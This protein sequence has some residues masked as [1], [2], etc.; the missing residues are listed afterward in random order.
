MKP[1]VHRVHYYETDKMGCVHHSN[2]IRWMEEARVA[3]LEELGISFRT[4]EARGI[5]SPVVG[6]ECRYRHPA[7]FDEEI[8]ILVRISSFETLRLKIAYEMTRVSDG[9]LIATGSSEH[10]FTDLTGRPIALKKTHPDIDA[11]LRAQLPLSCS[12]AQCAPQCASAQNK[13]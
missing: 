1:Y 4:M 5:Y 11:V 10:C 8:Q 13:K 9:D 2:H 12:D 6:V 7:Y 3:F